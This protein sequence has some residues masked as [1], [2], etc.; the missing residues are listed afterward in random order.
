[1][2]FVACSGAKTFN[3]FNEQGSS[4]SQWNAS[5]GPSNIVTFSFGG[6][7]VGFSKVM[8][9]CFRLNGSICSDGYVRPIIQQLGT[10]YPGFLLNVANEAVKPGGYLVVMGY[11]EIFEKPNLW[12]HVDRVLHEC[13]GDITESS[14]NLIRGWAGD[15]NATIGEAVSSVNAMPASQRNHVTLDF[16]DPV[17]GNSSLSKSDANLFEPASGTRHE[18]CSQGNQSWLNGVASLTGPR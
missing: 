6:D 12:P 10:I 14:A 9:A 2:H 8:N 5:L 18:L 1:L 3:F 17:S 13:E 4:P 15:L 16:V 7:D 11:P